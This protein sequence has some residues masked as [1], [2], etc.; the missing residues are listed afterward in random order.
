MRPDVCE[1]T[2]MYCTWAWDLAFHAK[3]AHRFVINESGTPVIL[4]PV[5]SY[6]VRDLAKK[7]ARA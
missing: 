1:L 5:V 2:P 7:Y 4:D 6:P 3:I